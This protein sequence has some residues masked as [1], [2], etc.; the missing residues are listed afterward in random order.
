MIHDIHYPPEQKQQKQQ[1]HCQSIMKITISSLEH[2]TMGFTSLIVTISS[3]EHPR[4]GDFKLGT[5]HDGNFKHENHNL[6]ISNIVMMI[7]FVSQD[8]LHYKENSQDGHGKEINHDFFCET[9]LPTL[10]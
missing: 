7:T 5:P 3:L 2:L 8:D 6:K 9:T 1:Q 10:P 4:D